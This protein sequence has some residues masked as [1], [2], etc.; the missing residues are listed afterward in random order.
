MAIIKVTLYTLMMYLFLIIIIRLMGKR[1]VGSLSITDLAV[2]FT[3]SDLITVGIVDHSVSIINSIVSVIVLA[4]LQ[5]LFS[6]ITLKSKK[7]RDVVEGRKSI[8]IFNGNIDFE[9]MKKQRYSID[10]LYNQ[11]RDKGIDS[12]TEIRWAILE[13]NGKLSIITKMSSVANFPDPIISDGIIDKENLKKIKVDEK[14]LLSKVKETGAKKLKEVKLCLYINDSL[15][16][17]LKN[18]KTFK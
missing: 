3:I 11:I 7:I 8:I 9:E 18:N 16:F 1:E 5:I 13:T 14:Y 6:Y 12:V 17:F 15:T 10:D 2:Y 4:F